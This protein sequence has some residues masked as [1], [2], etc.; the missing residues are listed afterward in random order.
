MN[1]YTIIIVTH[2]SD[3]HIHKCIANIDAQT[4]KADRIVISDSGSSDLSYLN[5]YRD[6]ADIHILADQHDIG[7]CRGNNAAMP[8]V[9]TESS[10][11][12]FLNP[13]AFLEPTF[14][15]EAIKTMALPSNTKVGMLSGQLLGYDINSDTPTGLYDSTGIFRTWYGH[16][17]DRDQGKAINP[18]TYNH[19]EEVPALCGALLF[20][21][22]QAIQD[23]LLRG[24]EVFDSS[25]YMYKDDIDLSLRMRRAGWKLLFVPALKAYHC[26]GWQVDRRKMR[27]EY[28]LMSA[29]NEIRVNARDCWLGLPYSLSKYYAVK[30][31]DM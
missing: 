16:W 17:Y 30:A 6:R 27:L 21:R 20:C 29:R 4:K 2:N 19:V 18:A 24:S 14:C 12:L 10:F 15:A 26:R 31:F 13:D 9:S 25:F 5:P 1:G 23:V 8:H 11:V 3:R 28:R 22:R 7:F